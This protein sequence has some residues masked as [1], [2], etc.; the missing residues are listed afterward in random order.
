MSSQESLPV[1]EPSP[2]MTGRGSS[3]VLGASPELTGGEFGMK[4][5]NPCAA[6]MVFRSALSML[7]AKSMLPRPGEESDMYPF[8]K[9]LF[10]GSRIFL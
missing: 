3:S 9:S 10:R 7:V 4:L 1:G 2:A 8:L 5:F 6:L